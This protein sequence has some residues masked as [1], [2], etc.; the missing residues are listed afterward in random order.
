[1]RSS[2]ASDTILTRLSTAVRY[3]RDSAGLSS[4]SRSPATKKLVLPETE[5][6]TLPRLRLAAHVHHTC[7]C[8]LQGV[9]GQAAVCGA[10]AGGAGAGGAGLA[11]ALLSPPLLLALLF[12]LLPALLFALLAL[13][14]PF[15]LLFAATG[16]V[17]AV[18][19]EAP[20]TMS[21]RSGE[22]LLRLLVGL[23]VGALDCAVT[24]DCATAS[25]VLRFGP[26]CV[27]SLALSFPRR[28]LSF[29]TGF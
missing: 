3:L 7:D 17:R 19:A 13:T 26:R 12:A 20:P 24:G 4:S 6:T 28:F 29:R 10:G 16:G 23:V 21:L 2:S 25:R 5:D 8:D 9:Q 18:R 11:D 22:S 15:V 14:L 27:T 1:M